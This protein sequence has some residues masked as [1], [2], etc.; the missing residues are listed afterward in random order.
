MTNIHPLL[1]SMID[2]AFPT[3]NNPAPVEAEEEE[4]GCEY[5]GCDRVVWIDDSD[6]SVGYY[7]QIAVCAS[8]RKEVD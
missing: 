8:C 7:D 5:C 4:S 3:L 2:T 1:Q 6:P